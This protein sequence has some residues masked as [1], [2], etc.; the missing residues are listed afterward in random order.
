MFTPPLGSWW[1]HSSFYDRRWLPAL[2]AANARGLVKRPRIHDLRHT[3]VA[4]LIAGHAP[5][6]AIQRRLGHKS[7]TTTIDRY[8]H[9]LPEIDLDLLAAIDEALGENPPAA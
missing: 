8:G 5:L 7:I 6:P 9:L 2:A 1:R 4:W 3:H